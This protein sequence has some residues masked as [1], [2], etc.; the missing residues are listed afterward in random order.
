[1]TINDFYS[2]PSEGPFDNIPDDGG[3]AGIFRTFAVIG[4]SMAA[5]EFES[6]SKE[7]HPGNHDM[8]EYSWPAYLGRMTGAKV[9]NFSRGGMTTREYVNSFADNNG[10]W[11]REKAAQCYIM[12]LGC[13]DFDWMLLPLG[14]VSDINLEDYRKNNKETFCGLY[15]EIIQRYRE[16][17]PKSRI[18]MC[19][20]LRDERNFNYS[21]REGNMVDAHRELLYKLTE[22]FDYSYVIDFAKY[23]PSWD[24]EFRRNFCMGE[25]YTPTGYLMAAKLTAAYI[26][27]IIRQKPEDFRQ[28]PFIGTELENT[29]YER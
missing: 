9:Y 24:D 12:A 18:F 5:G 23:G 17:S 21:S 10:F 11:D 20:M 7:G 6:F 15:G 26:D 28:V 4:D 3:F 27:Y 8:Y 13:N 1:M 2:K 22:I 25:H 19:T 16:I 29:R 14:D